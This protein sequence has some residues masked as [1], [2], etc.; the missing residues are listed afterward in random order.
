MQCWTQ[1][2]MYTLIKESLWKCI[3]QPGE[4]L[5]NCD[6]QAFVKANGQECRAI[7]KIPLMINLHDILYQVD[8]Y[9]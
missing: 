8:T 1:C 4:C 3:A 6:N 2:S 5:Q 9:R 7:R